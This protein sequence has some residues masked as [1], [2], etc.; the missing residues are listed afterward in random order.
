MVYNVTELNKVIK[1]GVESYFYDSF[2]IE[3]ELKQIV[4]RG[5]HA[6]CTLTDGVSSIKLNVFSYAYKI[7]EDIKVGDV[8]QVKAK[9]N[10]YDIDGTLSLSAISIAKKQELG[11]DILKREALKKELKELGYFEPKGKKLSKHIQ[12]LGVVTAK[13][14]AAITD[15][16]KTIKLRN[17]NVQI[18]LY[19]AKVQ[20]LDAPKEIAEGIREL[21]KIPEIQAIIVGRGGGSKE[22]LKAFDDRL[23]ADAIFNSEKYIVSA[24]GHEIDKSISDYV[25]DLSVSTPTQA[26][27][28]IIFDKKDI[29]KD[30]EYINQK[31]YSAVL[32]KVS[33][34]KLILDNMYLKLSK[35]SPEN[36][37]KEIKQKVLILEE[38]L[39]S[40]IKSFIKNK[41]VI[42]NNLYHKLDKYSVNDILNRGFSYILDENKKLVTSVNSIV[43]NTKIYT[44]LKDGT[45]ESF[46][47]DI[48]EK[49]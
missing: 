29:F 4:I 30:L 35:Y 33:N 38:K 36:R 44:Y 43:K 18:Y 40:K 24:V 32:N 41:K 31:I 8:V 15:I 21:N 46:V 45:I 13:T 20:G 26:V 12:Y 16:L 34:K 14:G 27:E 19:D 11:S 5:K 22:D 23:V 9:V 49:N 42:V 25:A 3:A 47:E 1:E 37:I 10:I 48:N 6:Y 39:Y 17:E 28:R 7:K 2:E